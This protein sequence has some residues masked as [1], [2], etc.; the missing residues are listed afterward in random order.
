MQSSRRQK[1]RL[2]LNF[3]LQRQHTLSTNILKNLNWKILKSLITWKEGFVLKEIKTFQGAKS[4][5]RIIYSDGYLIIKDVSSSNTLKIYNL[6]GHDRLP[7]LKYK[8]SDNE[9][10]KDRSY[11][12]S[13]VFLNSSSYIPHKDGYKTGLYYITARKL[14]LLTPDSGVVDFVTLPEGYRF[15]ELAVDDETHTLAVSSVK[16]PKANTLVVFALYEYYPRLK[17]QQT[18]QI[19]KSTFG[20]SITGA[21]INQGLLLTLH[22]NNK[23]KV[24]SLPTVCQ[25]QEFSAP[26]VLFEIHTFNHVMLIGT[27][28]Y[29]LIKATHMNSFFIQN[30]EDGIALCSIEGKPDSFEPYIGFHPDASPR[31]IFT[32][33]GTLRLFNIISKDG[34]PSLVPG[35]LH[36]LDDIDES[37][38]IDNV[39][40]TT[41]T[42]TGRTVKKPVRS[43]V[44]SH[45]SDDDETTQLTWDYEDDL[46]LLGVLY[47]RQVNERNPYLKLTLDLVD[48]KSGKRLRRI[49]FDRKIRISK[50]D[51]PEIYLRL[52]ADQ[53]LISISRGSSTS[54]LAFRFISTGSI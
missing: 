28:P 27:T 10:W 8:I 48:S 26:P 24:Y 42:R 21:E 41:T 20:A 30:L 3:I 22:K 12:I 5:S 23:V 53:C 32:D 31:L 1:N 25:Q 54:I 51:N 4:C 35:S 45:T 39:S 15:S 19:Q 49:E 40:T 44:Y 7:F 38:S 46:N 47:A 14:H 2:P 37:V 13:P 50:F 9:E 16:N 52:D 11:G 43:S 34:T 36:A 33:N 6:N 17:F 29:Y 18:L